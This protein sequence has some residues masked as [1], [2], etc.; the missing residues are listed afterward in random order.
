MLAR[1]LISPDTTMTMYHKN[2]ASSQYTQIGSLLCYASSIYGDRH[3]FAL[4]STDTRN[5]LN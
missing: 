5:K 1:K 4:V 3:H 2:W